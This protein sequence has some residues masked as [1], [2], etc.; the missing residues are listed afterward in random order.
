MDE[1]VKL[2]LWILAAVLQIIFM[3]WAYTDAVQKVGKKG[4]I[5]KVTPGQ[6]AILMIFL[7]VLGM[8]SYLLVRNDESNLEPD[9]TLKHKSKKGGKNTRKRN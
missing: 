1:Q 4:K 7:W 5:S 2:W 6:W 8:I 3:I 9:N